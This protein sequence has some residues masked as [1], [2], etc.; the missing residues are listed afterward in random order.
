M[1]KTDIDY[2][3]T[4]I[5]KITCKNKSITDVYVG[6]TTNFVQRKHAH[7][8]SCKNIKS[9]NHNCKLYEVIRANGGWENWQM[10]IINFF[11]CA[12]H[13]EARKREQEYFTSLNATLNS[14]EPFPK[15][16]VIEKKIDVV[17]ISKPVFFCNVCNIYCD[18]LTTFDNHNKTNKHKKN[19][20]INDKS[21]N[22][23]QKLTKKY[24]CLYC[25]ISCSKKT[26]WER[27]IK[28]KKH[29]TNEKKNDKQSFIMFSC[30][31]GKNYK[32][33][34]GLCM[35]DKNCDFEE[36]NDK[37]CHNIILNTSNK[38]YC[39][40]TE[41]DSNNLNLSENDNQNKILQCKKCNKKYNSRNGLWKHSKICNF[42]IDNILKPIE[43]NISP[44]LSFFSNSVL[45]YVKNNIEKQK[46]NKEFQNKMMELITI[47]NK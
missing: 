28:S 10:E 17:K 5:Y 45:E 30:K 3:N 24:A 4:I 2:S 9:L 27:H 36:N 7:K 19:I 47:M 31:C 37:N 14:I 22:I 16:K 32:D 42:E 11:N 26:E 13:Y 6:H 25:L 20:D 38:K 21:E 35:H 44:D 34:S 15:P 46:Q 33:R 41:S 40:N 1:P 12:D 23:S 43:N 39:S 8:Q 18:S 29:K